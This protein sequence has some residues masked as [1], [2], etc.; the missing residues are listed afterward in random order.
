MAP[1]FQV[2]AVGYIVDTPFTYWC[3]A[4]PNGIQPVTKAQILSGGHYVLTFNPSAFQ[5]SIF[6]FVTTTG[7]VGPAGTRS[8][9]TV[10]YTDVNRCEIIC[11]TSPAIVK[12]TNLNFLIVEAYGPFP[13]I[14]A[15]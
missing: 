13:S 9:A 12:P 3:T 7:M 1:Q 6:V 4:A 14:D 10:P 8:M 11:T 15:I 5:G 2:V